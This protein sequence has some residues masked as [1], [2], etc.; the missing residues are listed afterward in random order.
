VRT[1]QGNELRASHDDREQAVDLLKTAFVDGRLTSDELDA[2]VG[3]ALAAK[4]CAQLAALTT[5]VRAAS[6][7]ADPAPEPAPQ[8]RTRP[9]ADKVGKSATGAVIA[10]CVAAVVTLAA[11]AG[12]HVRPGPDA[13]ACQSFYVWAQQQNA[14]A[15][16]IMLLDFSVAAA[17]QGPDGALTADLQALRQAVLRYENPNRVD[18]ATAAV[19]AACVP[20]SN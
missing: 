19:D 7:E 18:V 6:I 4:T 13:V 20:Y 9:A 2:R 10:A 8:A 14:G 15:N 1:G 17:S 12:A 11:A 5:D 3:Q 16:A